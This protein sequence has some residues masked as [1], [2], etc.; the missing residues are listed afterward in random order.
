MDVHRGDVVTFRDDDNKTTAISIVA[1]GIVA[2]VKHEYGLVLINNSDTSIWVFTN[3]LVAVLRCASTPMSNHELKCWN[4]LCNMDMYDRV[5]KKRNPLCFYKIYDQALYMSMGIS[6]A[7]GLQNGDC[8][9]TAMQFYLQMVKSPP[10]G[11]VNLRLMSGYI[12]PKDSK[13]LNHT[14]IQFEVKEED[15]SLTS[16]VQSKS[17]GV[18]KRVLL[19]DWHLGFAKPPVCF[20]KMPASANR[21]R[22]R[23]GVVMKGVMV[24]FIKDVGEYCILCAEVDE[25]CEDVLD[26]KAKG[27]VMIYLPSRSQFHFVSVGIKHDD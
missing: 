11:F 2:E 10:A 18:H 20:P 27:K 12:F 7:N 25:K 16:F 9:T 5:Q 4:T 17:N 8:E 13:P 22:V 6:T 19:D 3:H 24:E 26:G 15:D 1:V 21:I 23:R 14:W